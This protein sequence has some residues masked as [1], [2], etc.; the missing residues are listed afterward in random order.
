MKLVRWIFILLVFV[1]VAFGIFDVVR[2]MPKLNELNT[3]KQEKETE[4]AEVKEKLAETNL[5][6]RG[7][8]ESSG[9]IPDDLKK[10]E[11]GRTM[12]MQKE[13][14]KQIYHLERRERELKRLIRKDERRAA[15]IHSSLK[16]RLI[17]AGG[18]AVLFLA[19]AIITG[20]AAIRS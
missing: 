7:F 12:K 3:S 8:L 6:Y 19:G 15:E 17:I 14:H 4:L 13:Y 20:R 11:A 18:L 16:P 2:Q 10:A 1:G 5:K 9:T